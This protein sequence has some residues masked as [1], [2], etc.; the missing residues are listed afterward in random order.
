M[1]EPEQ[2]AAHTR[3]E[4]L[5]TCAAAC[6]GLAVA[7]CDASVLPSGTPQQGS[8]GVGAPQYTMDV[9]AG[10]LKPGSVFVDAAHRITI[11]NDDAGIYAVYM[12]CTHL[13]CTP[14]YRTDVAG[15]VGAQYAA[16]AETRR[17]LRQGGT[18]VNPG[19]FFCPC[20]GARFYVDG[21]NFY[22][23][24]PRPM[25]WVKVGMDAQ[26]RLVV[27]RSKLVVYR[28]P[29]DTTFPQWRLDPATGLDNGKTYGV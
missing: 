28:R 27:D 23:P 4:F 7:A 3:R 6:A 11:V 26:R 21:T 10:D 19:G 22:G 18:S 14:L 1:I 25:D 16:E 17:N 12:I 15:D 2:P 5:G 29:G 9:H 8:G 24:A 20:H 13:G